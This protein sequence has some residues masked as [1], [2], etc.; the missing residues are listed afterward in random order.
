MCA[1]FTVVTAKFI[2]WLQRQIKVIKYKFL[3][4]T[5]TENQKFRKD[6]A[7]SQE[8]RKARK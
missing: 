1:L 6:S 8:N 7:N 2:G 3:L 5:V 4:F